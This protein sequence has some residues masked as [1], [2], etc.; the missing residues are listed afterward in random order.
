MQCS[1]VC[2]SVRIVPQYSGI[3]ILR[4]QVVYTCSSEHWHAMVHT[5]CFNQMHTC[6]PHL[7]VVELQYSIY[8]SQWQVV[9]QK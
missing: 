2:D 7:A 1:S 6:V 4:V 8:V 3:V 5:G 9:T